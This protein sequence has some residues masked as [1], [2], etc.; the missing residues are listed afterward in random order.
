MR[1]HQR[2]KNSSGQKEDKVLHQPVNDSFAK[3][4]SFQNSSSDVKGGIVIVCIPNNRT[5]QT[6]HL[7]V[8]VWSNAGK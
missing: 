3:C 2:I 8:C 4:F 5:T 1:R 7:N 6:N